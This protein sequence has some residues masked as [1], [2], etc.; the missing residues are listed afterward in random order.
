ME[1]TGQVYA[2]T[3]TVS[4]GTFIE[5]PPE[6]VWAYVSDIRLMPRLSAELQEVGWLDGATGPQAGRRFT[7][8]SAHPALG[9]WETVST[10]IEC[11]EPWRFAWAVGDPERPSAVWRFTLRPEGTGTVLEQQAQLG[12]ARSGLSRAIEAMPD[13]EQKIVFGRLREFE[14][15]IVVN[16]AAIKQLAEPEQ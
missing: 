14:S 7:G 10:V 13:K 16:L 8:R 5:A 6:A 1:R 3:P 12:P 11:D 9:S 4:A 2:D 15:G